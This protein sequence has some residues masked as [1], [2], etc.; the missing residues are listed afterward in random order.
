VDDA[1]AVTAATYNA[2]A[3]HFDEPALSFWDHFGT[4]TVEGLDLRPGAQ[5][6]DLCS[7]SGASAIPAALRVGPTG[8]VVAVDLAGNLLD[9]ARSKADRLHLSNIEFRLQD[10]ESLEDPAQS[11]DAVVI[12]FG[13]FFLPDM[14]KAVADVWRF[15]KPG[16]QLA[17]TTWG[18]GLFEPA[19]S[20]FWD[21]VAALRPDLHRGY[22]P[23]EDL[24][25]P[26]ALQALMAA[27]EAADV[28]AHLRR[29]T[30]PLVSPEDFWKVVQGSGYRATLQAMSQDEQAYLKAAV[31]GVVRARGINALRTD[32]V[33]GIARRRS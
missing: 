19:N 18:P 23:W 29:S 6:L 7:G 32:V 22:N 20:V 11:F 26:D 17:I 10:I 15:V 30:H 13:I 9:L 16:G 3:D 24:T 12:V 14:A 25:D 5:V 2:A 8:R 1:K 28:D 31:I 27:P 4:A 33:Y 21:A